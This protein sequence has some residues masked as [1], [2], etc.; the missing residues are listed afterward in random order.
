MPAAGETVAAAAADD[1]PFGTYDVS[2]AET[3][4]VGPGFDDLPHELMA[5][6]QWHLNRLPGPGVPFINVKVGAADPGAV[7]PNQDIVDADF[8]FRNAIQPKTRP[9]FS[10][11]QSL[12]GSL[13]FC[14]RTIAHRERRLGF[15]KTD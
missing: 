4:Y 6:D 15:S 7:H 13:P 9:R 11:Y 10:L 14:T 8:R 3:R 5:H 12:H 1:M 2:G